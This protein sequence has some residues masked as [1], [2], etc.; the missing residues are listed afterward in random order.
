M[1][2][3][4]FEPAGPARSVSGLF[5]ASRPGQVRLGRCRIITLSPHPN[6]FILLTGAGRHG[7][8]A[9]AED[10]EAAEAAMAS[11]DAV[12]VRVA[13]CA[14]LASTFS[15]PRRHPR[16]LARVGPG[17][18]VGALARECN[19]PRHDRRNDLSTVLVWSP[20]TRTRRAPPAIPM[21]CSGCPSPQSTSSLCRRRGL[22][23]RG[24]DWHWRH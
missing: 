19:H 18:T 8:A 2:L 3:A 12:S 13:R 1:R 20:A 22:P 10:T 14:A 9:P 23:L 7:A 24:S 17:R 5:R 4:C 6:P 11:A 16:P 15:R 21:V